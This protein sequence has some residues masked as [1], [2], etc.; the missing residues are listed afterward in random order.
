MAKRKKTAAPKVEEQKATTAETVVEISDESIEA[1]E[2]TQEEITEA[3]Q[4][5]MTD[6]A[7]VVEKLKIFEATPDFHAL[8]KAMDADQPNAKPFRQILDRLSATPKP[9]GCCSDD[10]VCETNVPK[11]LI[12]EAAHLLID[13]FKEHWLPGIKVRCTLMGMSQLEEYPL[14]TWKNLFIAWGGSG[15]LK[16]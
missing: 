1:I 8:Q 10:K 4:K 15:I 7:P 13:G 5:V 3:V 9:C 14:E 12:E 16:K 2:A 11:M 6:H